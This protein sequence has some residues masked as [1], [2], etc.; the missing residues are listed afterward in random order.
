MHIFER[1][2]FR[3][4]LVG[5]TDQHAHWSLQQARY[6]P[7]SCFIVQ[8]CPKGIQVIYSE[9]ASQGKQRYLIQAE[10]LTY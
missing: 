10:V 6:N 7:R 3:Q 2:T 9:T 5:P 8:F 1:F 4:N